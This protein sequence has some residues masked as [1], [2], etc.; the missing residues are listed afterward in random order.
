MEFFQVTNR[1]LQDL[2][3]ACFSSPIVGHS[4]L[5]MLIC[6]AHGSLY[7]IHQIL[8]CL[9]ALEMW[10]PYPRILL[11][12]LPTP[13]FIGL[14][15]KN[16]RVGCH[17]LLQGI[18]QPRIKPTSPAAPALAGRFFTAEPL[19]KPHTQRLWAYRW[20]SREKRNADWLTPKTQSWVEEKLGF[21]SRL[22]GSSTFILKHYLI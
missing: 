16:T 4:Y 5:C 10:F 3:I 7:S 21:Q 1:A 8:S 2:T 6:S 22:S 12:S 20:E 13:L 17:A 18:F 9:K 14:S 11:T 19:G 15:S